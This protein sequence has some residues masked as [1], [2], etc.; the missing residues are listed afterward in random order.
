MISYFLRKCVM[1]TSMM[2]NGE[3]SVLPHLGCAGLLVMCAFSANA[4]C[5]SVGCSS[6]CVVFV[7]VTEYFFSRGHCGDWLFSHG[8]ELVL[9]TFH[10]VSYRAELRTYIRSSDFPWFWSL[11]ALRPSPSCKN[12][13]VSVLQGGTT[14]LSRLGSI[15]V[16][17]S[18]VS[19]PVPKL[20]CRQSMRSAFNFQRPLP[21]HA[22]GT[23]TPSFRITAWWSI[24][25]ATTVSAATFFS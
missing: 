20:L 13:S 9:R 22:W 11:G 2:F 6:G 19:I 4:G 23:S 1:S 15:V 24:K 7:R 17:A 21:C 3:V 8:D 5:K 10:Q 16:G 25:G 18:T 12:V 14:I